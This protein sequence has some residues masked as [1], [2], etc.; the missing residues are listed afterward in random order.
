M[1][2]TI[3]KILSLTAII[4]FVLATQAQ[5]T[6][7]ESVKILIAPETTSWEYKIGEQVKFNVQVYRY[8]NPVKNAR[9]HYQIMPEKMS[10]RDSGTMVLK[11]GAI[12]LKAGTMKIPGFLRCH[13]NTTID[14]IKFSNFATAAFEPEKIKATTNMP[15]DFTKFW[16]GAKSDLAKI[17]IKPELTLM[18]ELSNSLINVYHVAINNIEG[19]IYGVLAIPKKEGKYP[20]MLR[21]PGAGVRSYKGELKRA[22]MGMIT[23][24]I[25]IHGIPVNLS[26]E[27]YS[28]LKTGILRNYQK[29]NLDDRDNYYYKRVILGCI[30]TIDFIET[31]PE[32]D[33]KNLLVYGGSQGGALTIITSALDSRVKNMACCYPAL[34]DLQGYLH[35]RAGGWPHL[36]IDDFTNKPDKIATSEYYDVVNFARILKTP[37][38]YTWGFNDNVC[39]PTSMFAAY[40]QIKAPKILHTVPDSRHFRYPE[41]QELINKWMYTKLG[42]Q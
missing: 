9:I 2:D 38:I 15:N 17:P 13:V 39:P 12:V 14:G 11:D 42:V 31:I 22:E 6:A 24:Y 41:Q 30:R 18:P 5:K 3:K 29:Y 1:M 35:G 4:L 21:V 36:F 37:G 7:R 40:N 34:C 32:Y 10:P 8:G 27:L 25:G 20:V 26:D 16:E 19:K 33:G 28:S 23:L